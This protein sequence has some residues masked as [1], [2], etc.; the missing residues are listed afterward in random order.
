MK[1]ILEVRNLK[2][3]YGELNVLDGTSFN[4][5]KGE[6][7]CII[8]PSGGGKTTILRC[9]GMLE[10]FDDGEI[11]FDG[12]LLVNSESDSAD[13]KKAMDKLG[14]VFQDFNLW[15]NKSVLDNIIEPLVLIKKISKVDAKHKANSLLKKVGLASKAEE[16]PDFLSGGQKQRVAIARTLAMD[17]KLLLFDEIT[18]ALD[19]E[20]VGGILKLI[21]RLA[22]EGQ[23]M[24]VVTHHLKFASEIADSILFME[25]GR[26]VEEGSPRKMI[27][28]ADKGRTKKFLE[29]VTTH[30]QE[31]NVY[32]GY[33]D[34]RAFVIGLLKRVKPG[35][36]CYVLGAAGD[37]WYRCV[38]DMI[39]EYEKIRLEKKIKWKM[40]IYKLSSGE[41]KT[42]KDLPS[43]TDYR[44]IPNELKVPSNMNIWGDTVLLQI[45]GERPAIIE[46]KNKDLAA[47]YINY[48][49]LMWKQGK[50]I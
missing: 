49:K 8:G 26:V 18:S 3:S 19:P 20:L 6:I 29:T 42:L 41:K 21:K 17:P 36:T 34:F 13:V 15:P 46:I 40:V 16:F 32:E 50:K 11:I 12:E 25:N 44:I 5:N 4:I 7:K 38:G 14:V 48:F 30:G 27:Y 35:T 47:G 10:N 24:I 43:L 39:V 33:E 28:G 9:L 37:E 45:F 31:I 23:T 1:P 2:K 22:R